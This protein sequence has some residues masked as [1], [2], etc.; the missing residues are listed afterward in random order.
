VIDLQSG[1]II[2]TLPTLQGPDGIGYDSETGN[3]YVASEAPGRVSV[4]SLPSRD[5]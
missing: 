2:D 1:R 4:I 5:R 3:V